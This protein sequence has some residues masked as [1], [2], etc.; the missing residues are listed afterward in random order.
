MK[1]IALMCFAIS[2]LGIFANGSVWAHSRYN[3]GFN[4]GY[5]SPGYYGNFGYRTYGYRYPYFYPPMYVYPPYYPPA[6]IVPSTPPVYIQ[7]ETI[8][9]VQPQTHYWN[10]CRNPE[11]YYPYVKQCPEGW[12]QISPQPS[13]Q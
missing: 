12:M 2:L 10:Y 1:K 6:V 13:T 8:R 9:P 3:F 5:Y 11:G 7:N 4:L